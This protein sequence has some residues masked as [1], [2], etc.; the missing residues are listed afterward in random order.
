MPNEEVPSVSQADI[1]PIPL[2]KPSDV[3]PHAGVNNCR[4]VP[5][6]SLIAQLLAG[7]GEEGPVD[8]ADETGYI[9]NTST[10]NSI[11]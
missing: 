2:Q 10:D 11:L 7:T 9:A 1:E 6:R 4:I 8:E 3:P 5:S